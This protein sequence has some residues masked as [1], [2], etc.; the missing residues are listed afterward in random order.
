MVEL[1][2]HSQEVFESAEELND[3]AKKKHKNLGLM[4]CCLRLLLMLLLFSQLQYISCVCVC[5][6]VY[7]DVMSSFDERYKFH[8]L[9]N[10][11]I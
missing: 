9:N 10:N 8:M 5:L 4:K 3:L 2:K 6:S 11:R 1:H 7:R